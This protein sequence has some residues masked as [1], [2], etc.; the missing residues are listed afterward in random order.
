MIKLTDDGLWVS[1]INQV[2]MDSLS[3][4]GIGAMLNVAQDLNIVVGWPTIE[5]MQ[6]GLIDGPGNPL[7]AYSSAVLALETLLTRHKTLVCCHGGSRSMAVVLMYLHLVSDK[8]WTD[9]FE[10][11]SEKVDK[12]LPVPND[13]HKEA[14]DVMDWK[15][16]RKAPRGQK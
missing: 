12:L 8:G 15:A 5:Y 4:F 2:R 7:S 10:I 6:V 14:F 11:L 3:R 13:V 1:P 9:L 16:L